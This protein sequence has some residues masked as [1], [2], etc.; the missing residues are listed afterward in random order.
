MPLQGLIAREGG[1]DA[2]GKSDIDALTY[3]RFGTS[4]EVREIGEGNARTKVSPAPIS[5]IIAEAEAGLV[6]LLT[7]FSDPTHPYL[8]A[9]RPERVN[10]ESDYTRL[11]RRAEWTGLS[12][13]D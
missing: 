9:P 6:R 3:L 2:I 11:A 12:T 10:Y 5:E 4:F 7:A 1:Y 13:Y 8:S